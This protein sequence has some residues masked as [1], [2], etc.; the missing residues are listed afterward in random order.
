[1]LCAGAGAVAISMRAANTLGTAFAAE[2]LQIATDRIGDSKDAA[3]SLVRAARLRHDFTGFGG[4][5]GLH[6]G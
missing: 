4:L 2:V 1:M 3:A 6:G 5:G